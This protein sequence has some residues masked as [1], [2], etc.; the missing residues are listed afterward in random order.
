MATLDT[1][2]NIHKRMLATTTACTHSRLDYCL[3][4]QEYHPS[5]NG[6]FVAIALTCKDCGHCFDGV[7]VCRDLGKP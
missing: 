1:K 2:P 5:D 6:V 3:T 7:S 4:Y